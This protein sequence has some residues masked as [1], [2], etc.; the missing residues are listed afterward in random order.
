M[1]VTYGDEVLT[2]HVFLSCDFFKSTSYQEE[3]LHMKSS[4]CNMISGVTVWF[5]CAE[6][7][8]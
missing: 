5:P 4:V 7:E 3:A 8:M 1:P 6:N 2:L